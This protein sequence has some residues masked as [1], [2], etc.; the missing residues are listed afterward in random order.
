MSGLV[1]VLSLLKHCE[2]MFIPCG[3]CFTV[4]NGRFCG[5]TNSH[6]NQRLPFLMSSWQISHP[7]CNPSLSYF[8]FHFFYC[9]PT[10]SWSLCY[11]V[12]L[13]ESHSQLYSLFVTWITDLI[14]LRYFS[15][16]FLM[17]LLY[18]PLIFIFYDPL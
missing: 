8:F 15:S 6:F 3:P 1:G 11:C 4:W 13:C 5:Q 17:F 14:S 10:K 9:P 2:H 18:S 16:L 7:W 12:V